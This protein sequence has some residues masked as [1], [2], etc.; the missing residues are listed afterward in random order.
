MKAPI[1]FQHPKTNEYVIIFENTKYIY[2]S[3][4]EYLDI[5]S[6]L[7]TKYI[8]NLIMDDPINK[9]KGPRYI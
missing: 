5:L 9:P 4:E 7:K 6:K 1:H 2:K 3:K 8:N